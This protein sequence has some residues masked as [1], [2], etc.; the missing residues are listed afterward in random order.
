[1]AYST[2]QRLGEASRN[3]PRPTVMKENFHAAGNEMGLLKELWGV[4]RDSRFSNLQGGFIWDFKDQGWR[5]R[6]P[7][8]DCF[9]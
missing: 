5:I 3:D 6:T 1:M 2:P 9:D 4:I 8:G 7:T